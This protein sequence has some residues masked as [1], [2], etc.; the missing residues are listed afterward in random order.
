MQADQ[1]LSLVDGSLLEMVNLV[2]YLIGGLTAARFR[3]Q[4]VF[5]ARLAICL[6]VVSMGRMAFNDQLWW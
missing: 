3:H 4:P 6:I 2:G 1:G 5:C